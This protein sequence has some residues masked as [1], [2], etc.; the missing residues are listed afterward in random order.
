M[1][2]VEPLDGQ[3]QMKLLIE[4]FSKFIATNERLVLLVGVGLALAVRLVNIGK[5]SI[6]FDES[7][8]SSLVR[9]DFSTGVA[10]TANDVHPPLYYILLKCWTIVFGSSDLALR[11]FSVALSMVAAILIYKFVKKYFGAHVALAAFYV[12]ALG[13]FGVHFAQEARMYT[14]VTVFV[15]IATWSFLKLMDEKPKSKLVAL[16]YSLSIAAA[17]YTH[18]FAFPIVF[19][20]AAYAYI[21]HFKGWLPQWSALIKFI[22]D[23]RLWIYSLLGSAALFGPWVPTAFKQMSMVTNGFWIPPVTIMAP[24]QTFLFFMTNTSVDRIEFDYGKTAG[25]YVMVMMAVYFSLLAVMAYGAYRTMRQSQ[26]HFLGL[27]A[28]TSFVPIIVIYLLSTGPFQSLY[29]DRY[30]VYFGIL[31]YALVGIVLAAK[32]PSV[33]AWLKVPMIL[34]TLAWFLFGLMYLYKLGNFNYNNWQEYGSKV[35]MEK[36][37]GEYREG[38]VILANDIFTFYDAHHYNQTP[39]AVLADT[40]KDGTERTPFVMQFPDR[41]VNDIGA[42]ETTR[43]WYITLSG[44]TPKTPANWHLVGPPTVEKHAKLSL[45]ELEPIP[46]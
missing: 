40:T 37:N 43:V 3:I 32:Q 17:L 15:V 28:L 38:D 9:E 10:I 26:K 27:L 2:K 39:A 21:Y 11:S 22:N 35:L 18:Y 16:V 31:W 25:Q 6:W 33:L 36:V 7:F 41:L 12:V 30:F 20:H 24:F 1:H 46:E 42:I 5:W 4:K 44:D 13:P 29:I 23:K 8:T 14:L 19:A 45:Y 34:A